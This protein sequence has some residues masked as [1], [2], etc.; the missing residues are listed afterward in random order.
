MWDFKRKEQLWLWC[1]WSN[2][3]NCWCCEVNNGTSGHRLV[4]RVWWPNL[5][6][7]SAASDHPRGFLEPCLKLLPSYLKELNLLLCR[8]L[9]SWHVLKWMLLCAFAVDVHPGNND[10]EWTNK[11]KAGII[12]TNI[13]YIFIYIYIYGKNNL[14]YLKY[15][16]M[17]QFLLN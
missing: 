11:I 13:I 1:L 14:D 5:S 12:C 16:N 6:T 15:W 2:Q 8:L 3:L 7:I 4:P 9:W 10:T 17:L